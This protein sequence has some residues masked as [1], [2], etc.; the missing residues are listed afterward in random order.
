[1][2]LPLSSNL[3]QPLTP[4]P[5]VSKR[6]STRPLSASSSSSNW[7][8]PKEFVGLLEPRE[9]VRQSAIHEIITG[10]AE[11]LEDLKIYQNVFIEPLQDQL[12]PAIFQPIELER[13]LDQVV[14][15]LGDIRK[16]SRSFLKRLRQ[17]QQAQQPFVESIGDIILPAVL[18]WGPAYITYAADHPLGELEIE[19]QI[20]QN[21]LFAEHISNIPRFN[22]R[23][24]DF[25]HFYS[26]ATFRLARYV[27]LFTRLLESTPED[28]VDREPLRLALELVRR[29]CSE[30][31]A[32]IESQQDI[33][34]LMKLNSMIAPKSDI[35]LLHLH[36]SNRKIYGSGKMLRKKDGGSGLGEWS[37]VFVVLFDHYFVM[38]KEKKDDSHPRFRYHI[39]EQPIRTEF[40]K[41]SGLTQPPEKRSR[42]LKTITDGLRGHNATPS[43]N[44]T[45][46]PA[47]RSNSEPIH[48]HSH[49]PTTE[50]SNET[51]STASL[52]HSRSLYPMTL[53]PFGDSPRILTLYV[54]SD[55]ARQN[56]RERF[57]TAINHRVQ[58]IKTC[59]VFELWPMA[60][61]T[62]SIPSSSSSSSSLANLPSLA[63]LKVLYEDQIPKELL[64][65]T[66]HHGAPTCSTPFIAPDGRPLIAIGCKDGLW[67][68]KRNN[69]SSYRK[70]LPVKNIIQISFLQN[71]GYMIVLA[72]QVLLAYPLE[73]LVHSPGGKLLR[74]PTT[75]S[76]TANPNPTY[77][78][79]PPRPAVPYH[80]QQP[81]QQILS[82]ATSASSQQSARSRQSYS[83]AE[84]ESPIPVG[85]SSL[86]LSLGMFEFERQP[87]NDEEGVLSSSGCDETLVSSTS[88]QKF[89][90]VGGVDSCESSVPS[91]PDSSYKRFREFRPIGIA[92]THRASIPGGTEG[93]R[94]KRRGLV[95]LSG[96][97]DKVRFF[98]VGLL[99]NRLVVIY[100]EKAK[101]GQ[102]AFKILEPDSGSNEQAGHA[103]T[104]FKENQEF[105][106]PFEAHDV[107]CHESQNKLLVF[108]GNRCEVLNLDD[109]TSATIPRLEENRDEPACNI[110]MKRV[111][112][113]KLLN[114]LPITAKEYLFCYDKFAYFG[115]SSGSV[116]RKKFEKMIE[117]DGRPS[118]VTRYKDY[119]IG[120][121]DNLIEVWD[122]RTSTRVQIMHGKDI[123]CI[124]NGEGAQQRSLHKPH[125][126]LDNPLPLRIVKA[127]SINRNSS[128][129]SIQE[130]ELLVNQ[131]PQVEK[132][133]AKLG[134]DN[135]HTGYAHDRPLSSE[136]LSPSLLVQNHFESFHVSIRD[137]GNAYRVFEMG[138]VS[139]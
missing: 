131:L 59:H 109:L 4:S 17:R 112:E 33:V 23:K 92:T 91:S 49:I 70:V 72:G 86:L 56:W 51:E 132:H 116:I 18:E 84:M 60:L 42:R 94:E 75:R 39:V 44:S 105:T 82:R 28:H 16:F 10:E 78:P 61:E 107:L 37:E 46:M 40:L 111:E 53:Q 19:R 138:H 62:F 65:N 126:G 93:E 29:Q 27:L 101:G 47:R 30:C 7:Q 117:W 64:P 43:I 108:H 63:E 15:T 66:V 36:S 104:L 74:P 76:V 127:N 3:Q 122:L 99:E 113:A 77:L 11:Y 96:P 22:S 48:R 110:L 135:H 13:F 69:S 25:R 50:H 80:Q 52:Q 119:V 85:R 102:T 124:Y 128:C 58:S 1:M 73:I 71:E 139:T 133:D 129:E 88:F 90:R 120:Y 125:S 136:K 9:I 54:E 55:S 115:S 12:S 81:H 100:A 41:I 8:I 14:S 98:K 26:R 87:V 68:G 38:L 21:L 134:S 35:P 123:R 20:D 2:I 95:K 32:A 97:S 89:S 67:I 57:E 130:V 114:I 6:H 137:S 5:S 24:K 79:K 45:S 118:A 121:S 83:G 103:F 31:N 34:T 106:L